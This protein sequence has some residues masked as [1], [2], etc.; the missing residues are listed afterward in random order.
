MA[1]NQ[2]TLTPEQREALDVI[3]RATGKSLD[4]L[5][6]EAIDLLIQEDRRTHRQAMLQQARGMWRDRTDLPDFDALRRESDAR[7]Y[8]LGALPREGW[9]EQFRVMAERGDDRLLDGDVPSLTTW[10]AEEWEWDE[11][12][13]QG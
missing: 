8:R 2:I 11:D 1:T 13:S 6:Q 12:P 4:V 9:E 7:L 10:D 3:A 5:V